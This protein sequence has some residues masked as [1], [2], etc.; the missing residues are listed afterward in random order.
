[1]KNFTFAIRVLLK[2]KFY[3]SINILGL[4]VGLAVSMIIFLSVQSDLSYDKMHTRHDR[5]YRVTSTYIING[6]ADNFSITSAFLPQALKAEYPLD[7]YVPMRPAG[8]LLFKYGAKNLYEQELFYADSSTFNV[9]DY[10]LLKGDAQT[11]LG[12]PNSIILT[13]SLAKK[14]FGDNN[15]MGEILETPIGRFQVNG[16]MKDL[17]ENV[18]MK[19]DGF[20]SYATLETDKQA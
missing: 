5:I 4:A 1:M 2:D 9:L 13:E 15:A 16:I 19:V 20:M 18:H 17:R 6:K 7:N 10:E 11:A 14:H 3:S 12:V 8:R